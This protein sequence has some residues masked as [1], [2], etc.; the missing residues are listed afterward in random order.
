MHGLPAVVDPGV[1]TLVLGSFPGAASLAAGRYYAHARNQFWPILA[2]VLDAP[3]ATLPYEQRLARLVAHAIGL[4]DV[5][6]ACE[7]EGSLDAAIRNAVPNDIDALRASLPRLRRL[8]FNGQTAGRAA[9]R[10]AATGFEV[11]I[12][13]STSPAHAAMPFEA[14]VEAWRR[15][16]RA[17]LVGTM[18][19]AVDTKR[20]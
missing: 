4:W 1:D 9:G 14:K 17:P 2:T 19:A 18:P 5:Y 10:F 8:V 6:A 16:L 13:P 12:A 7:R 11:V 15:A 20:R 3:L